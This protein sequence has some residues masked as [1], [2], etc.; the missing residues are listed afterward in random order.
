V[1]SGDIHP[2]ARTLGGFEYEP[3]RRGFYE[4]SREQRLALC[5]RLYDTPGFAI[6]LRNFREIFTDEKANAEFSE[7]LA[8]PIS[9]DPAGAEKLIP[10]DHGFGVQRVPTGDTLF[11]ILQSRQRAPGGHQR[12][13]DRGGNRNRVAHHRACL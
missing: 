4:V 8:D 9:S 10:R 12:D 5:D 11:R 1:L 13:A 6:W 2:C 7:Y 3:D